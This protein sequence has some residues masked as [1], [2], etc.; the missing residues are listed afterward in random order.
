MT[1]SPRTPATSPQSSSIL[2]ALL[3]ALS[4]SGYSLAGIA[5]ASVGLESR[6]V[7]VPFRILVVGISALTVLEVIRRGVR[8]R[9]DLLVLLFWW[10]YLF[11]LLIDSG[12]FPDVDVTITFFLAT[13][14]IPAMAVMAASGTYDEVRTARFLFYIGVIVSAGAL[15]LNLMGRIDM[16][17]VVSQDNRL[18]FEG[19]NAITLGH[20]GVSAALAALALWSRPQVIG[21]RMTLLT[22]GVLSVASLVLS[23]SRGPFLALVLAL[24]TYSVIRG[25]W[26]QIIAAGLA[27]LFLIPSVLAAQGFTLVSRFANIYKDVSALGRLEFQANAIDQGAQN[28]IFGSAYI[29]LTSGQY[30]HNLFVESFMAMGGG[31]L[32]LFII[33][34]FRAGIR[35]VSRLRSGEVLLPIL[36]VQYFVGAQLSGSIWG[37]SGFWICVV[38]VMATSFASRPAELRQSAP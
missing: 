30:P 22:G 25:R 31:G 21:G 26:G 18:T 6:V 29:E 3:I 1:L 32:F 19:L 10:L 2:L 27:L 5:L 13:V 15:L 36:F 7:S 17:L 28:P 20:V 12:R 11:R 9:F 14:V 16:E 23:G 37:A 38:L 35:A 24:V 33:I 34:S 4:I 8:F